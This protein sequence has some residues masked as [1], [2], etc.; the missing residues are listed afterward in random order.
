MCKV[1]QIGQ[2]VIVDISYGITHEGV[3]EKSN[4][5]YPLYDKSMVKV[6]GLGDHVSVEMVK[7]PDGWVPID[8]LYDAAYRAH[9]GTSFSPEKRAEDTV[10]SYEQQLNSDLS[11]MPE[12]EAT[13]YTEG[14]KKHLFSWL[15][16]KS[17]CLSSMITGP[18]N[19]PV[20]RNQKALI[21]ERNRYE[22]FTEWMEKALKAI[23]KK[24]EDQKPQEQK[25]N[26]RLESLRKTISQKIEWGS[27]ANCYSMI[28]RLAYNGEVEL[29]K[30]CLI[31]ITE[32]NDTH[33]KPFMTSRHKVWQLPAIAE[34]IKASN[35]VK[36]E[37][38][39][40]ESEINGVK[41]VRNHQADRIQLFFNGKPVPEI[42]T[43]LKKS[44]FKWSPTN[45]C[46]QR[47]LTNNAIYSAENILKTLNVSL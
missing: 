3:I 35:E 37:K 26:E 34:R 9:Q 38:E 10:R 17:R 25:I 16:A 18:A 43:L 29:V 28:E 27:V 41:V 33:K 39:N 30:E 23:A 32:Y 47:Q 21:S 44:A 22:E 46:W 40:D 13:R 7:L 24:A 31:L 1:F 45:G 6:S 2:K 4:S 36:A 11:D 12:T 42:I 20:Q 8:G 19:F 14:Y 15:S 5:G